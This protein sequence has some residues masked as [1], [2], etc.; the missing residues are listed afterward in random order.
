MSKTKSLFL[1]F[2]IL[3][4][5]TALSADPALEQVITYSHDAAELEWGPCPEFLPDGCEIAVLHGDPA[6]NNADIFF[7]VPPGAQ[8]PR[9]RH[10]SAERMVLVSG[11]LHV[12]YDG[13][14]PTTLL[15]GAYAF[16][17]ANIPHSA[18]CAD[19]DAPCV[20]FIAFEEP[21]DAIPVTETAPA[22]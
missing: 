22:R 7:K 8:I 3:F 18:H 12:V 13:Y 11:E 2:P 15:S 14:A 17:P 4:C 9:H 21:L 20:L 1:S 6:Q 10:T 19:G 5:C 16:G